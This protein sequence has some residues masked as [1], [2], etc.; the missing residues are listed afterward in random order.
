MGVALRAGLF[1]Y[2]RTGVAVSTLRA[3]S[4]TR[5]RERPPGWSRSSVMM[6]TVASRSGAHLMESR[7]RRQRPLLSV[8]GVKQA[9]IGLE[10]VASS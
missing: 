2:A 9:V 3:R 8:I 7:P 1:G 5:R 4:L 10:L 6:G